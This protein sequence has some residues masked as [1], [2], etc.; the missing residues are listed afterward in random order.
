MPPFASRAH[1]THI[2][3][4]W[5]R[6][7]KPRPSAP[8]VLQHLHCIAEP[9][10]ASPDDAPRCTASSL[11][12]LCAFPR[13]LYLAVNLASFVYFRAWIILVSRLWPNTSHRAS[14]ALCFTAQTNAP[15]RYGN[16]LLGHPHTGIRLLLRSVCCDLLLYLELYVL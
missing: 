15:S 2:K 10:R 12:K 5:P 9:S 14:Q 13:T 6:T 1:R 3:T 7:S 11:R 4:Q 8:M 16:S